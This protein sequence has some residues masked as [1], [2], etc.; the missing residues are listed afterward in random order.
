MAKTGKITTIEPAIPPT[1]ESKYGTM[2]SYQ[3]GLADG[4][5]YKFNA[6]GEFKKA[7][8]DEIEFEVTNDQYKTA[9]L[10]SNFTPTTLKSNRDDNTTNSILAQVCY[11]ANKE[12]FGAEYEH[13]L[14]EKTR[15][16][17]KWMKKLI[18]DAAN[19][20]I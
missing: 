9:K 4:T 6:K 12:I 20:S 1:Y 13:L 5:R 3:I 18:N 19:G 14:E 8:G 10:I 7:V 11:K 15:E 17:F 16:D 2:H